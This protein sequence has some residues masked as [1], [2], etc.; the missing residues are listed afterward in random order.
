MVYLMTGFSYQRERP[1]VGMVCDMF[2]S[3]RSSCS[4]CIWFV[5]IN[6][7][8]RQSFPHL[9]EFKIRIFG[10]PFSALIVSYLGYI[11]ESSKVFSEHKSE[12]PCRTMCGVPSWLRRRLPKGPIN[13]FAHSC[14]IATFQFDTTIIIVRG[15]K[16]V[17]LTIPTFIFWNYQEGSCV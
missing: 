11:I 9:A 7:H 16:Y 3:L 14:E 13:M 5:R 15:I 6:D 8:H 1:L 17:L 10:R 4:S 12:C 2:Q